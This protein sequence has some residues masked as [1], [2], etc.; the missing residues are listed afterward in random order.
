V[1]T[2]P[3]PIATG[4]PYAN[5]QARARVRGA[6]LP[7]GRTASPVVRAGLYLF[8]LSLP[9]EYPGRSIPVEITTI[10]AAVFVLTALLQPVVSFG[11]VPAAVVWFACF[12][13]AFLWS[14]VLNG[15]EQSTLVWRL[16]PI[17]VLL[18]LVLWSASNVLRDPRAARGVLVALAA[19]CVVRA[20]MPMVGIARVE[21]EQWVGGE[22]VTALGQNA[23]SSAMIL[24]AGL[25]ALAG[26]TYA[27]RRRAGAARP[28]GGLAA[29]R[30]RVPR[31][32][33]AVGVVVIGWAIIGTG[34]RGGLLALAV[35]LATLLARGVALRVWVRSAVLALPVFG[36]LAWASM[37]NEAMRSRLLAAEE[38]D[39]AGRERLY[40]ALVAMVRER[41]ALG[42]GPINNQFELARRVHERHRPRRDAHNIVLEVLT[43]TGIAGALPFLAGMGICAVAAWRARKGRNGPLALAL[44]LMLLVSNMSANWIAARTFWLVMAFALAEGAVAV[45]SHRSRRS[46]VV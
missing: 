26:L 30:A 11:R 38:G 1:T 34:S 7:A 19:A 43:A 35:G 17:L 10:T 39:L 45:D 32:I 24:S 4:S 41:P 9:F 46:C 37:R 22:R 42:W 33:A 15:G 8:V 6:A 21:R 27:R 20:A 18:I 3:S 13:P 12:L 14:F 25:I 16:F 23:N 44:M 40:P 5:R 28:R 31:V 36:L 2:L 29:V